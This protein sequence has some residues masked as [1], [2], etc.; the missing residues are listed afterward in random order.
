MKKLFEKTVKKAIETTVEDLIANAR[1]HPG[2]EQEYQKSR[3]QRTVAEALFRLRRAANLTQTALGNKAGWVQPYVA[4][5]ERGEANSVSALEG[6]ERYAKA[7]EVSAVV[8]FVDPKTQIV[9]DSIAL[10]DDPRIQKF[11]ADLREV[12]AKELVAQMT[13]ESLRTL[14]EHLDASMKKLGSI[15]RDFTF[16]SDNVSAPE[17]WRASTIKKQPV[18]QALKSR[19][20]A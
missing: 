13:N 4:R 15:T 12:A 14:Q 7:C 17:S 6:V 9:R 20:Q 19:G 3:L 11:A 10:G 18:G 2:F 8:I 16:T 5:L 1:T